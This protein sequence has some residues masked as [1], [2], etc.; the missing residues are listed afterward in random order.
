M[1][2]V[3]IL[4]SSEDVKKYGFNTLVVPSPSIAPATF[5]AFCTD[6][7]KLAIKVIT[8]SDLVRSL[9]KKRILSDCL[10]LR[11]QSGWAYL[12][13]AG[14]L[15]PAR[16]TITGDVLRDGKRVSGWTWETIS[17][18]LLSIQETGVAVCQINNIDNVTRY[19]Q[20]LAERSRLVKRVR[21][22]REVLFCEPAEDMLMALPGIGEKTAQALLEYTGSAAWALMILTD[23][24]YE[25]AGIGPETRRKVREAL[26]IGDGM[27][28][29]YE[30]K[31]VFEVFSEEKDKKDTFEVFFGAQE[32]K[33]A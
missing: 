10:K 30:D 24:Q 33:A 9:S 13:I 26:G 20:S 8:P 19:V 7:A 21:P 14:E 27:C 25:F 6:G 15:R 23:D 22:A 18:M 4:Q 2:L 12:I 29:R 11:E 28:F 17:N 16:E 32:E 3:S 1:T 5:H 31:S